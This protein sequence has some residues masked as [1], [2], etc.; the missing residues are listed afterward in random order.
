MAMLDLQSATLPLFQSLSLHYQQQSPSA[1]SPEIPSLFES[2][3]RSPPSSRSS[4]SPSPTAASSKHSHNSSRSSAVRHK[5]N[6]F[7]HWQSKTLLSILSYDDQLYSAEKELV[8]IVLGLSTVQV[9]RWFCNARAREL[10]RSKKYCELDKLEAVDAVHPDSRDHRLLDASDS[11]GLGLRMS[12]I[13]P[14][15]VG[16][17]LGKEVVSS[18]SEVATNHPS[19][20][21]TSQ[22]QPP[23][24]IARAPKDLQQLMPSSHSANSRRPTA[25]EPASH[26]GIDLDYFLLSIPHEPKTNPAQPK[27]CNPLVLGQTTS[28]PAPAS[29]SS[30][31]EWSRGMRNEHTNINFEDALHNY[32]RS[33][34][35]EA[36]S[37][38]LSAPQEQHRDSFLPD[39]LKSTLPQQSTVWDA[40]YTQAS[41]TPPDSFID[42]LSCTNSNTGS[43]APSSPLSQSAG[44]TWSTSYHSLS[45][46]GSPNPSSLFEESSDFQLWSPSTSGL[47]DLDS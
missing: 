7:N 15:L 38:Q 4:K 12:H 14:R 5:P 28:L 26:F 34:E 3:L 35:H 10:K 23:P 24:N 37:P 39:A 16:G 11:V 8:G 21:Q 19:I 25:D 46:D 47:S 27:N 32:L 44:S 22:T 1:S 6:P 18:R 43:V 45:S 41:T 31:S 2:L 13:D 30:S 9:N 17:T 33:L 29:S 20:N 40:A 42:S 36:I